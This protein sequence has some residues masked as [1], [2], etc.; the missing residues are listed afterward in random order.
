GRPPVLAAVQGL[1]GPLQ[2]GAAPVAEPLLIGSDLGGL[3]D[4]LIPQR[5]GVVLP[6]LP[7]PQVAQ[8]G[9]AP[10]LPPIIPEPAVLRGGAAQTAPLDPHL[11]LL[12]G[13]L[14]RLGV[15]E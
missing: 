7:A 10:R 1:P 12:R 11:E 5:P 8:G 3:G 9:T 13:L 14:G 6:G 2:Q 4:R 15:A